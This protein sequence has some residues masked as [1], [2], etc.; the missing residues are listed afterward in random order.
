MMQLSDKR[1]LVIGGTGFIG[2][3]IVE[4]LAQGGAQITILARNGERAKKV[5][6]V[7]CSW[8]SL[9]DGWQCM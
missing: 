5:E 2:R 1:I 3:S 7:R 9:G 4:Q 6:T 8:A